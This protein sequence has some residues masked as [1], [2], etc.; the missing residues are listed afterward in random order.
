VDS[1]VTVFFGVAGVDPSAAISEKIDRSMPIVLETEQIAD[2]RNSSLNSRA[3]ISDGSGIRFF[4]MRGKK[5][6]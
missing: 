4:G 2:R 6:R 5:L 3:Q 1:F